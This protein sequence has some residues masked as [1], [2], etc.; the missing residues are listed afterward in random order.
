[1]TAHSAHYRN[2][3]A[4]LIVIAWMALMLVL[5]GCSITTVNRQTSGALDVTHKSFLIK[6]EAPSLVVE[7]DSVNEY[8]ASFNAKS[9]GGD[10]QAMSDILRMFLAVQ[11]PAPP[12]E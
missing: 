5:G 7:R 3:I 6:T 12:Q 11:A 1:M 8:N 9:R 4:V 10:L 2:M